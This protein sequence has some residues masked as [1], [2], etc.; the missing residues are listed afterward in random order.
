MSKKEL[1]EKEFVE[2]DIFDFRPLLTMEQQGKLYIDPEIIPKNV[3]YY[4]VRISTRDLPDTSRM[5]EMKR[6]RWTPVPAERHPEL[7]FTDFFGSLERYQGYIY[8][9]GLLLCERP[10]EYGRMEREHFERANMERLLTMPGTENFLG[11]PGIPGNV[12]GGT[13]TSKGA[14]FPR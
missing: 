1:K 10:K 2:D 5:V 11:E 14:A 3:D 6:R 4:W 8:C 7:V 12:S 9:D 13:Y